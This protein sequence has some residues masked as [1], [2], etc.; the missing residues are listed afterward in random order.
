MAVC[1]R[2]P[3]KVDTTVARAAAEGNVPLEGYKDVKEFVLAHKKPRKIMMLVMAGKPVDDTIALLTEH[4]EEG[5]VL[6]VSRRAIAPSRYQLLFLFLLSCVTLRP[7]F[8]SD[9]IR[10]A[11]NLLRFNSIY[12]L[13]F[14]SM[15]C[16]SILLP[17]FLPSFL[18]SL[19]P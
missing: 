13:L 9:A 3:A 19:I 17:S 4:M 11:H 16:S 7:Q 12:L 14:R 18:P 6:I 15:L 2:S 10:F 8:C 5:D 1:N